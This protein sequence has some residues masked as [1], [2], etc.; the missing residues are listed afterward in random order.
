MPAADPFAIFS[1]SKPMPESSSSQ[2]VVLVLAAGRGE[3]FAASGARVHKLEALLAGQRVLDHVLNAVRQSGLPHHVVHAGD[4]QAA[5]GGLAGMGDSIAVGVRA[6][7][8]AA[9]WMIL[10]GDLPLIQ[11][12][13]LQAI[14]SAP[15]C[16]VLIPRFRGQRGHPVRFAASCGP[17]LMKLQGNT[18]AAPVVRAQAAIDMIATVDLDDAGIITDIDT[19]GDLQHAEALLM[20]RIGH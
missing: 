8:G 3:R 7:S 12:Q 20:Q 17:E 4:V 1:S 6:T 18:G 14:A 9:G 19:L 11:P 10:P 15:P 13:T 16:A 2:P 5:E